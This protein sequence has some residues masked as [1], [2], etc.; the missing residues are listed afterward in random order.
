MASPKGIRDKIDL[1][2][3]Y[4]ISFDLVKTTLE[5]T[6]LEYKKT[7]PKNLNMDIEPEISVRKCDSTGVHWSMFFYIK[8][9]RFLLEIKNQLHSFLVKELQKNN[10]HS[11]ACP[12][13]A[14][15][16]QGLVSQKADYVGV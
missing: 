4:A 7:N 3:T 2:T 8:D 6:F 16:P 13:C 1:L 9:P 5:N 15:L 12:L 11:A 10:I 14:A